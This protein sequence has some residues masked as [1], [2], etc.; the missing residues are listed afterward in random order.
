MK[1]NPDIPPPKALSPELSERLEKDRERYRSYIE[2]LEGSIRKHQDHIVQLRKEWD[3]L[4]ADPEGVMR[5]RD[6]EDEAIEEA[7]TPERNAFDK[8]MERENGEPGAAEVL[9]RD[10]PFYGA[11]PGRRPITKRWQGRS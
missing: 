6:E 9:E 2:E 7:E 4:E 11:D 5:R 3:E 8:E 1:F 10:E